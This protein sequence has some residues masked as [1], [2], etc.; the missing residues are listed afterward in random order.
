MFNRSKF[1]AGLLVLS[2]ATCL[3]IP[4]VGHANE[5]ELRW[6]PSDGEVLKF[7]VLRKGKP[8]GEHSVTFNVDGE[9]IE[10]ANAIELEVS[11]GPIRAFYYEHNSEERWEDGQLFAM[12][13]TTRKDGDDL[14]MSVT[15]SEDQLQVEGTNFAGTVPAGIIPSSHWNFEQIESDQILSS[16]GGEV[17]DVSAEFMGKEDIEA[18][19][20]MIQ[21]DRYRLISDITVDLWYD[22]TGR[23]VKCAF[24]ARGQSI[25]YVLAG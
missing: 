14:A 9:N 13:G 12:D 19:G 6:M 23:W 10:V 18:G 4:R 17:L 8:F 5:D 20:R 3:S 7:D 11:F 21:A 25:E 24:E 16:E 2:I 1:S 22:E 15:R